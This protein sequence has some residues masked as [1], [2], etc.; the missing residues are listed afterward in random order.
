MITKSLI[1]D[2]VVYE[3]AA[4]KRGELLDVGVSGK[5]E[6]FSV[7]HDGSGMT[8][9]A[10]GSRSIRGLVAVVDGSIHVVHE[11]RHYVF[12]PKSSKA[13]GAS[14]AK[15]A[16]NVIE[17]PMTGTVIDVRCKVGETVEAGQ[18]LIIVSAMKME[19]K[20]QAPRRAVVKSVAVK[21]NDLVDIGQTLIELTPEAVT[22]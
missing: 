2:G 11:G 5:L 15:S 12:A 7:L 6:S 18:T 3:L 10:A 14:G 20:L 1:R 19:H 9:L 16:S 13:R 21:A 4:S 8:T 17:S 22:A